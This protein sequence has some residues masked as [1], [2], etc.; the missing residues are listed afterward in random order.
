MA[1]REME[2]AA[3]SPEEPAGTVID[4]RCRRI[5]EIGAGGRGR[6]WGRT[7]A[8]GKKSSRDSGTTRAPAPTGT[9]DSPRTTNPGDPPLKTDVYDE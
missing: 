9:A 3:G 5:A 4:G 2:T 6:G 7:A 8:A 1:G